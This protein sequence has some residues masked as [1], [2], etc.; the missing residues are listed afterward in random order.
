MFVVIN[1]V[2]LAVLLFLFD[3][4]TFFH[5][6]Y[7]TLWSEKP[8]IIGIT[9]CELILVLSIKILSIV[10]PKHLLNLA[11]KSTMQNKCKTEEVKL[12]GV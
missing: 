4:N 9:S 2:L 10:K 11:R 8:L 12:I 5:V 6:K 1:L 7:C 3:I